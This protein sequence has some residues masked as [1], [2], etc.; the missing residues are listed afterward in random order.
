[1]KNKGLTLIELMIATFVI[2][3]GVV[4]SFS[5]LQKVIMSTTLSSSRLVAA[6]LAQE[7]IEVVRN[8]RDTNWVEG[9]DWDNDISYVAGSK[10]LDYRSV[11]YPDSANCS[12][13]NYLKYNQA[14]GFYECSINGNFQRT[15]SVES[16]GGGEEGIK[17]LVKVEWEELGSVHEVSA[18]ENLYNWYNPGE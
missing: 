4:G 9:E 1:M 10:Y 14:S 6:Y 17:V 13:K 2:V 18:Q 7:G 12:S 11:S 16:I 5:V 3:I 15:I 8:I